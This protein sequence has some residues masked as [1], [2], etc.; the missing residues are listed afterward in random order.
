MEMASSEVDMSS[1]QTFNCV[2]SRPHERCTQRDNNNKKKNKNNVRNVHV[3]AFEKNLNVFVRDHLENCSVSIADDVDDSTKAV[4]ECSSS[5]KSSVSDHRFSKTEESRQDV[6]SSSSSLGS[7]QDPNSGQPENPSRAASSLVQ[8]WEARTTQQPPSSNQSLIDSRTSSMGSNALENSESLESVKESE[9][10]QPIEEGNNE[11]EEEG[12]ECVSQSVPPPPDSGEKDR[13]GVRVMD[14]IRK[15]SNDSETMTNNDN[16]SSSNDNSKEVQTTEARSF[17]QVACSP[18]IRGRQALA[19]LLVQMT[20]DREKDLACLRERH[21]VSKFTN[22]GRIQSTL[23]IRC[24]EMCIAIQ[25]RHR[26]KSTSAG[27]D[28]NRSSRGSGVMHLLR[29]KYKGNSENI[30]TG[31][32]SSNVSTRG[33]IMDKHPHKATEKK[34]L[35]ETIEKSGLKEVLSAVENAKK[36]VLSEISENKS[37][38]KKPEGGTIQKETTDRRGEKRETKE[39]VVSKESVDGKGEKQEL[40][41]EK[42]IAKENV[43]GKALVGIAE[44]VNLWNSEEIMNRRKVVEKGK[45]VGKANTERVEKN[46]VLEEATRRISNAESA[47]RSSTTT[48]REMM[49]PR[50]EFSENVDRRKEK[51]DCVSVET[52]PK[53][54][55]NRNIKPQEVTTQADSCLRKPAEEKVL[56]ETTAKN[57]LKKPLEKESREGRR[58]MVESVEE[59]TLMGIAEKVNLW[60]SKETKNRRRAM[61]KGKGKTEGKAY[62]ETNEVLQEASRRI[63]NVETAERSI[64]TS[65]ET[66]EKVVGNKVMMDKRESIGETTRS[67]SAEKEEDLAS[68]E[69]KSKEI[70]ENKNMNPQAASGFRE[71]DKE[72]NSSQHGEAKSTKEIERNNSQEVTQEEKS[73]SHGSRER[74]KERSSLQHCEKMSFLR[75][76]EAKSTTEIERNKSQEVSQE[77][78]STSQGSRERAK[79]KISSQ[80]DDESSVLRNPN[81]QNG[82]KESEDEGSKKVEREEKGENVEAAVEFVNVWD[83]NEIEEEE[84]E[85]YGE[86]DHFIGDDDWIHD[87]SRPRSYWEDLRKERYLEVL[88]T[89]SEKKDICNLI[90]RRTVSNF[91]TSDLRQKIDNLM[92]NRV[93]SHIGVPLNQ[94]EEGDE[95]EEEWE[96]ECSA[97]NQEDNEPEEEP[98]KTNLEAASDVCSQS[99]ARSSTMM[100]WTFRDQDIDKDNEPTT[101]S[102]SLL[103]PSV[104]TDQSTQ[105]MQTISDLRSQME[106]LQRE[107]LELRNSVKSCIDMQL[108][109][110]KSVTQDLSRSEQRVDT[111]KDPL[112]RKCCVCSEMPVDSLLYRCGHMCTCLKCAHELQWSSKKCPI[113]MAPIVD[114]VRAFLDS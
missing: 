111:K 89:E 101:S 50:C 88:N 8:I 103:E 84:D 2:L 20:R 73:V 110:Q 58:E 47:E 82:I 114:V 19:D 71:R 112:K 83:E 100:S 35:Q 95:D 105:D 102:L 22:R 51:K 74:D 16:G 45:T 65:M 34:V 90:E 76:S 63:S 59:N 55:E 13:E 6:P 86:Y 41:T 81:D 99:S 10:I 46:D 24:Y 67:K 4:P 37:S 9:M 68:V 53:E 92:I 60:N 14:I 28:S 109:F 56:Q 11:E 96:V 91:L 93:Q 3:A 79:E 31:A 85:E 113:C 94:I 23:R 98:E 106:Q 78:D 12:I 107:M 80:Q 70:I 69:A 61:E 26:S 57:D 15:L 17:P 97:R 66:V 32:S 62:N 48:S 42:T 108:H 30:E 44:K 36:A 72:K 49:M 77:E 52:K 87:I 75:N 27:S 21:C 25:G 1:C 18:R 38:L 5:N 7:D 64:A 43:D 54:I 33:R 39:K 40:T 104:P 29:E